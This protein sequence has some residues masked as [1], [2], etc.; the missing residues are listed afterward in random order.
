LPSDVILKN[1]KK[2]FNLNLNYLGYLLEMISKPM[3]GVN[4]TLLVLCSC[5]VMHVFETMTFKFSD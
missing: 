5:D 2:L 4:I 1:Q 3:I